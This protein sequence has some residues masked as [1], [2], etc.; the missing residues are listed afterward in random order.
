VINWLVPQFRD[1]KSVGEYLAGVLDQ[2]TEQIILLWRQLN[3]G[4]R[5]FHNPIIEIDAELSSSENRVWVL[6]AVNRNVSAG[7]ARGGADVTEWERIAEAFP[8]GIT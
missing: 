3:C 7:S 1:E 2:N 8:L 5:N 4:A 6:S